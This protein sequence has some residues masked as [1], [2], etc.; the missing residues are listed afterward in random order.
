MQFAVQFVQY[1]DCLNP[2]GAALKMGLGSIT[3]MEV[4]ANE[5]LIT[6]YCIET[7]MCI[8]IYARARDKE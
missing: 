6:L 5:T 3:T 1:E 4:A 8:Y 7:T 2:L